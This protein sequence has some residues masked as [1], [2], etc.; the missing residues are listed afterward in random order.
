[1]NHDFE[2]WLV[3][4]VS[5]SPW[6]LLALF[7]I[8]FVLGEVFVSGF[9]ML[10]IGLAFLLTAVFSLWVKNWAVLLAVLAVLQVALFLFF[11]R[12]F[13]KKDRP[14]PALN[15]EGMIGAECEV[16]EEIPIEGL[17][18]V[19]LYGDRWQAKSPATTILK[20]GEKVIIVGLDGNKVIVKHK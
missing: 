8:L 14:A 12:T 11:Q 10:P 20:K 3:S 5:E 1:M 4:M 13:K 18:Y 15:A 9:F 7:G 17:G 19:K 6:Q 2:V 16:T